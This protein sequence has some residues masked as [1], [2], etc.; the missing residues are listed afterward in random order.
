MVTKKSDYEQTS[1]I[2]LKHT[3]CFFKK[4]VF[5]FWVCVNFISSHFGFYA[6]I[7]HPPIKFINLATS[8]KTVRKFD[9]NLLKWRKFWLLRG[10][11]LLPLLYI[12][13]N[14]LTILYIILHIFYDIIA[15]HFERIFCLNSLYRS[16]GILQGWCPN[17]LTSFLE[18]YGTILWRNWGYSILDLTF[19]D[20][21]GIFYHKNFA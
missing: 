11:N 3:S 16:T 15:K 13:Q 4:G 19:G 8:G 18:I 10:Q 20:M 17:H 1:E 9:L 6:K 21:F 5:N 12:I 2:N 14:L 7:L